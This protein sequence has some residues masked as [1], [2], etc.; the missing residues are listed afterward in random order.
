MSARIYQPARNAMQSGMA[1]SGQ[2]VLEYEP[3]EKR[4]IDPLMGWTSSNDMNSQ[5]KMSFDSKEAAIGFA[6]DKGLAYQVT[7]P[8]I[9]KQLVREGGYAENFASDRKTIWTH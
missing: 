3:V 1:K 2:W 9:R 8:K 4:G 7:E 5:V 6:T